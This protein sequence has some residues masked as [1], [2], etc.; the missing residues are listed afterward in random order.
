MNQASSWFAGHVPPEL[1]EHLER[2]CDHFERA[3]KEHRQPRIEDALVEVPDAA[4]PA[5]LYELLVLELVYRRQAGE[6][7]ELTAYDA[8]FPGYPESIRAA[9]AAPGHPSTLTATAASTEH[10]SQEQVSTPASSGVRFRILRFHDRGGLGDVFVAEDEELHREVA[11]K[12]IQERHAHDQ[13]SRSRF[14]AEAEITGRLEHPGI[15]PVYGLGHYDDGRP[16]YA[17]RFIKGDSLKEAI[18]RFHEAD[19]TPGRDPGERSLALCQLLRRFLDVCNAIAYAHSRGVLHR[20]LK[21][22]NVLLGPYG[23]TLVVDWGLAKVVGRTTESTEPTR[24]EG[25]LAPPSGGG[26]GSTLPGSMVGTPAYMSPEQAL[27]DL[28]RLGPASDVYSLGAT[29]YH[30]LSGRAAFEDAD[31]IT[32]RSKI[33]R[34]EFPPPRHVNPSVPTA[35]EAICLKAM[36]PKPEDRYSNPRPLAGD[37]EHWLADEP[38]AAWREPWSVRSRRW[39]RR[40]RTL[41][42]SG[43]VAVVATLLGLSAVLAVQSWFNR[44]LTRANENLRMAVAREQEAHAVAQARFTLARD[45]VEAYYTGTSEDVLLKRP[46]LEALRT[47]LLGTALQYYQ[48]LQSALEEQHEE[49]VQERKE[50]AEAYERV[51]KITNLIGS[52]ADALNAHQRAIQ[53]R[54][55][56]LRGNR[57]DSDSLR[58]LA[59]GYNE[60]G[61][62]HRASGRASEAR[63]ALEQARKIM[64]DVLP[65]APEDAQFLGTLARVHN[66]L[67]ALQSE[68]GEPANALR[69]YERALEIRERLLRENPADAQLRFDQANTEYNIG[70]LQM[71]LGHPADALRLLR[72]ARGTFEELTREK[73]DWARALSLLAYSLNHIGNIERMSGLLPEALRSFQDA[74]VVLENLVHDNP[75]VAEY[76]SDLGAMYSNLG[77]LQFELAQKEKAIKFLRQAIDIQEKLVRAHPTVISYRRELGGAYH[78]LAGTYGETGLMDEALRYFEKSREVY[79]GVVK[80]NAAEPQFRS[81]LA[82]TSLEIGKVHLLAG[83][84][85][86]ALRST[87]RARELYEG[88]PDLRPE[89]CYFLACTLSRLI[90]LSESTKRPDEPVEPRR[91]GD[92]AMTMLRRAIAGGIGN[93]SRFRN[94]KDLIALQRRADF[95]ALL[96]DLAFPADPFALGRCGGR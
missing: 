75:T 18:K 47:K 90:S 8:R 58:A 24:T 84:H 91:D 69:C 44:R 2:V 7:P 33:I 53:I 63:H 3:W 41:A 4:R 42:T 29:L 74:S 19:Q 71:G 80:D 17:M 46:E 11:L 83:R 60:V 23:E 77:G 89:D 40:H 65:S 78:N 21:P 67:G 49:T 50:L 32:V 66:S 16:F 36:A 26:V 85:A 48:K 86:E 64:E 1:F 59:V 5:L 54:E 68:T 14:V 72:R 52:Q 9:F 12:Q 82:G 15:I 57:A 30:L 22:G 95:Q 96:M 45:A 88:I 87:Q 61:L 13:A 39:M 6:S 94:E 28:A 70:Y 51:G 35:L 20:D 92:R 25:T 81:D 31:L 56:L 10:D 27:G 55:E 79:E 62:I 34:G 93:A 37:V 43:A 38:V 76:K 73:H